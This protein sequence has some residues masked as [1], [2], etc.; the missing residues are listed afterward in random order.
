MSTTGT[1]GVDV[2]VDTQEQLLSVVQK[3]KSK[4]TRKTL[5][6]SIICDISKSKGYSTP[7]PSFV[8]ELSGDDDAKT[9]SSY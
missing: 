1:G 9:T 4:P 8:P 5:D 2:T 7:T 3:C 6:A